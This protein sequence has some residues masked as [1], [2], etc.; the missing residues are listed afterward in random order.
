MERFIWTV[1]VASIY[2]L[3]SLVATKKKSDAA[4]PI[5]VINLFLGWTFVGWVVALA[6]AVSAKKTKIEQK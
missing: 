4:A 6:W 3:P 1:V 5:F 2:L